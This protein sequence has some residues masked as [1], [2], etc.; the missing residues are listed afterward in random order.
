MTTGTLLSAIRAGRLDEVVAL[1]TQHSVSWVAEQLSY[2]DLEKAAGQS[3]EFIQQ[4]L[5]QLP[6]LERLAAADWASGHYV[7]AL[8][9]LEGAYGT[10]ARLL[11]DAQRDASSALAE[12]MRGF[13]ALA[14]GPDAET[15][16]AVAERLKEQAEQLDRMTF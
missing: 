16:P 4:W 11:L 13:W 9:H 1:A 6:P 3:S 8:V 7:T 12:S 15:P 5:P 14:D 10:A 2:D